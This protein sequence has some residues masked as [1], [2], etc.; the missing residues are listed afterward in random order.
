MSVFHRN[1]CRLNY[2]V[3]VGEKSALETAARGVVAGNMALEDTC[4]VGIA[5]HIV[6]VK[7]GAVA[8]MVRACSLGCLLGHSLVLLPFGF[9][10]TTPY[11][12]LPV[13]GILKH[14]LVLVLEDLLVRVS[15]PLERFGSSEPIA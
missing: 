5:V 13:V 4:D 14:Q 10:P 3:E 11:W 7:S 15:T 1:C 8:E 9:G 12:S 2:L 6:T